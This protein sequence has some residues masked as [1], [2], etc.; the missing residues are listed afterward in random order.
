VAGKILT[1]LLLLDEL[2]LVWMEEFVALVLAG[3]KVTVPKQLRAR[4][5]VSDGCYVRLALLEV[6]KKGEGGVWVKRRVK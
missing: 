6:L 4:F 3:G 5:D 2:R 1:I